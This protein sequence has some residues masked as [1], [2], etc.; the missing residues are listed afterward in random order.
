MAPARGGLASRRAAAGRARSGRRALPHRDRPVVSGAILSVV[1]SPSTPVAAVT[2]ADPYPYYASLVA[3]RPLYRDDALGLW[4]ASSAAAVRA[5]MTSERCRVR[6]AAEPVPKALVD[7]PAGEIF[8]QLVRMN[9]GADHLRAKLAVSG[10]LASLDPARV[11]KQATTCARQ[12]ADELAPA[13]DGQR[14]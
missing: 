5:V 9:D 12:L 3:A 1:E 6:P 14:L 13:G 2:H 4:V 11:S 7:S 8:G 10:H